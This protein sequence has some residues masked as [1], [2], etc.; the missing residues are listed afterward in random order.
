MFGL[1]YC[2]FFRLS[3]VVQAVRRP[4]L[5]S[6]PTREGQVEAIVGRDDPGIWRVLIADWPVG[7]VV[8]PL[9]MLCQLTKKTMVVVRHDVQALWRA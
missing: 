5:D 4:D 2:R 9:A 6:I 3:E 7:H 8:S 1:P